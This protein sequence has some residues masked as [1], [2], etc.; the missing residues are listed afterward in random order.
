VSPFKKAVVTLAGGNVLA[1]LLTILMA[2]IV[3]RL[4]WPSD[5]G[6]LAVLSSLTGLL[7]VLATFRYETVILIPKKESDAFQVLVG[8]I[9]L[10]VAA[11]CF[12][13]ILTFLF[14]KWAFLRLGVPG[15][16]DYWWLLPVSLLGNASYLCF[17]FWNL[18]TRNYSSLAKTRLLQATGAS[19]VTIGLGLTI[20]NPLGLLL[21]SVASSSLG[22]GE[23]ARLAFRGKLSD[24]GLLGFSEAMKAL[25]AHR[26]LALWSVGAALLNSGS[27][28]ILPLL[29]SICFGQDAAGCLSLAQRVVLLPM[30]FIG[31]AVAQ[32]FLAEGSRLL[33]ESPE[34]LPGFFD[35]VSKKLTL[36]AGAILLGAGT[37]PFLF[38]TFFGDSWRSAGTYAG[39][40]SISSSFQLIVSPISSICILA[41]KQETQLAIDGFRS[42]LVVAAIL[43][44]A[45]IGAGP[46]TAL[47]SYAIVMALVYAVSF[48]IYR[49][50]AQ[51]SADVNH[52]RGPRGQNDAR[53]LGLKQ[54]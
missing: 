25:H 10:T 28:A 53:A 17:S 47:L 46:S 32:V 11:G 15:L 41:R 27:I 20:R 43:I 39:L 13:G 14:G 16:Y 37:F 23:L 12:L 34:K 18:R 5:M 6:M 52:T 49:R 35:S 36:G 22:T 51:Q 3:T 4:Y 2:P 48:W 33:R 1:Q 8:T 38:T 7:S 21:G 45:H 31:S 40:L 30:S 42:V 9:I 29:V 24:R 54:A 50:L 44:P 26:Q 19:T